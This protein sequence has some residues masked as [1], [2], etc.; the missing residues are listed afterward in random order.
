MF[1]LTHPTTDLG[2]GRLALAVAAGLALAPAAALAADSPA[3]A[4]SI[5]LAGVL[6][7]VAAPA[8]EAAGAT[9]ALPLPA[10]AK[11]APAGPAPSAIPLF[12]PTVE[13]AAALPKPSAEAAAGAPEARLP[14]AALWPLDMGRVTGTDARLRGEK[15]SL[16]FSLFVPPGAPPRALTV[17]A[18]SS[19]FILPGRSRLRVYAGDQ[20]IG[21]MPLKSI[22]KAEKATFALPSGLLAPGFNRIR[23]EVDLAHR[24]YCGAQ[25]SYDLWTSVDLGASGVAYPADQLAA[26][27]E[28]F[29]AA[30]S[31]ARGQGRALVIRGTDA[32]ALARDA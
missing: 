19:A 27:P 23:V 15:D 26:G 16:D 31:V 21:E 1:G 22:T 24:L 32:L 11:A 3:P 10:A 12:G 25:A 20:L 13:H 29:L 7:T 28:A 4:L 17:A 2:L 18:V 30:A 9:I 5:P 8:P 6:G 14:V